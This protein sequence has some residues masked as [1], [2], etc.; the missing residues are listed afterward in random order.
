M[1]EFPRRLQAEAPGL[2]PADKEVMRLV[3][4]WHRFPEF[5]DALWFDDLNLG[6]MLEWAITPD[7]IRALGH[8][9][10]NTA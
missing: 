10:G 6:E 1:E 8:D 7:V 9:P 4:S 2:E 3:W 5:D